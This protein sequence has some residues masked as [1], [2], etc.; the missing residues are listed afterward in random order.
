MPPV[1]AATIP[2][3]STPKRSSPRLAAATAPLSAKTNVPVK[4]SA[5]MNSCMA[6][7]P[8][9]R[10]LPAATGSPIRLCALPSRRRLE[11]SPSAV[12]VRRRLEALEQKVDEHPDFRREMA[13]GQ[14]YRVE[15]SLGG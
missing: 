7:L 5:V 6:S 3:T 10:A 2:S 8:G 4:S 1:V 12:P 11:R 9:G 13:V 15:V 14:V